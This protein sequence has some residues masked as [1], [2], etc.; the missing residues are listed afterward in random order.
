MSS[1]IQQQ[2]QQAAQENP[3]ATA[4]DL[5]VTKYQQMA[6]DF[7]KSLATLSAAIPVPQGAEAFAGR[8]MRDISVSRAF[9]AA[10]IAAASE[11][12]ELKAAT[13]FD[14][15]AA[16]EALQFLDAWAPVLPSLTAFT[17]RLR[18]AL[19]VRKSPV[20]AQVR[21]AYAVANGLAKGNPDSPAATHA[22]AMKTAAKFGNG[23]KKK[24]V[25][26]QAQA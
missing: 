4:P 8:R 6:D 25:A 11:V 20:V 9:M 3:P 17:R 23:P 15:D 21:S 19:A 7:L 16:R 5:T 13:A 2:Q 18:L 10:G 26:H 24:E 12:P 14:V 1:N 22:Q